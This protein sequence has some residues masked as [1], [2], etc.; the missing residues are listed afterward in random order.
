MPLQFVILGP[1]EVRSGTGAL[2]PI[3]G[4]RERALLTRLLVDVTHPVSD[5]RLLAELWP[6]ATNSARK[7]LQVRVS[8]LRRALS[9]LAEIERTANGYRLEV[10]PE[11]VDASR[12]ERR[13]E[14]AAAATGDQAV[15]LLTEALDL[16]TP[17]ALAELEGTPAESLRA[18][19]DRLE[20][21]A[22]R[23][24]GNA[25]VDVGDTARAVRTLASLRQRAPLD[26]SVVKALVT[27]LA[28]DGRSAEALDVHRQTVAA[29]ADEGLDPSPAFLRLATDVLRHDLAT[30]RPPA[31]DVPL[32]SN[33]PIPERIATPDPRSARAGGAP[34][35]GH[36]SHD[37]ARRGGIG[38]PPT[39]STASLVPTAA[40]FLGRAAAVA[41]VVDAVVVDQA[42]LVT[43]W[44]PGGVGKTRLAIEV[45][46]RVDDDFED[47]PVIV[48]GGRLDGPTQLPDAIARA[49]GL[50]EGESRRQDLLAGFA[51]RHVLV[52]LDN[53]EH[54]LDAV[55]VISTLLEAGPG[56][57]VLV[58]SRVV[59][60][61]RDERVL[62]LDP[63]PRT[64]DDDGE[65]SATDFLRARANDL[66]TRHLTS[67][68]DLA[69][70]RIAARLDGLP[71]ALELAAARLRT[72]PAG[73]LDVQLADRLD[74]LGGFRGVPDRQRTLQATL[75]WSVGLLDD[76]SRNLLVAVGVFAAPA[77]LE[78]IRAVGGDVDLERLAQLGDHALVQPVSTADGVSAFTVLET[79]RAWVATELATSGME[80]A[81]RTRHAAHVADMAATAAA[82]LLTSSQARAAQRLAEQEPDLERALRTLHDARD[83]PALRSLVL[84]LWRWWWSIG[85]IRTASRWLEAAETLHDGHVDHVRVL[86]LLSLA[87][88]HSGDAGGARR[89]L[90]ATAQVAANH[91]P[92]PELTA[93]RAGVALL[94]GAPEE[95]YAAA[96]IAAQ[97]HDERGEPVLA[98]EMRVR[99]GL[100]AASHGDDDT[101]E[102]HN[103]EALEVLA[104]H[105]P[106]WEEASVHNNLA[107]LAVARGDT[108]TALREVDAAFA[109]YDRL[110]F[111]RDRWIA[112]ETLLS[113]HV[114]R[115]ELDLARAAGLRALA[116]AARAGD[117]EFAH[118]VRIELAKVAVLDG[119]PGAAARTLLEHGLDQIPEPLKWHMY[120][121][122][123]HVLS[124]AG[125][126]T[127]AATAARIANALEPD[128]TLV[129]GAQLQGVLNAV[130]KPDDGG[131]EPHGTTDA[132]AVERHLRT[133]ATES[134]MD[135]S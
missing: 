93:A 38:S 4:A 61:L 74:V 48:D 112:E 106:R 66:G 86:A 26:E 10:D 19:F 72:T 75:A 11:R 8:H 88:G 63:L 43:V 130:T 53:L 56:V 101:C 22:R 17:S 67:A 60:G 135:G 76:A 28:A 49:T 83:G 12:F 80:S 134:A 73:E 126:A 6:Q 2:L 32:R 29:L 69:L 68:D 95:A 116:G 120:A 55:D 3:A 50:A 33:G 18:R 91:P 30:T 89:A 14:R 131:L 123:A 113:I 103:R 54:L 114:V 70:T 81:L 51:E 71:L 45:I 110:P 107:H 21:D 115:G 64:A 59:L 41:T 35:R 1:L 36:G 25:L 100:A 13:I 16:W 44:G 20:R 124:H 128:Q 125:N 79:V 23:R 97:A 98:A 37:D 111:S 132:A 42:R 52:L 85:S 5:D 47:P 105:G 57:F 109:V 96:L 77:R 24:L 129:D 90:D 94:D 15:A 108:A 9:G 62:R 46:R 78:G 119:K 82:E 118:R 58:T 31:V 84:D 27:A 34:H 99:A 104:A 40:P 102:R 92:P 133:L 122:A 121:V 65:I 117:I 127:G 39:T 87:R 7:S